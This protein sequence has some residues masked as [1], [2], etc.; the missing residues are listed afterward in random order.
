MRRAA[1]VFA[2]VVVACHSSV[3]PTPSVDSGTCASEGYLPATNGGCPKGTCLAMDTSAACCGSL[4]ATCEDKGLVSMTEAGTCPPGTMV[5]AD[6]TATLQCCDGQ[7]AEVPENDSGEDGP[8]VSD[9]GVD[10][11][12]TDAADASGG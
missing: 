2:L 6:L 7:D 1:L 8:P 12:S 9:G 11:S 5:A 4:C 3:Q 10:G